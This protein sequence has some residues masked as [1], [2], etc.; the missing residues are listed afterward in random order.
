MKLKNIKNVFIRC[1]ELGKS[2][3]HLNISISRPLTG[4][5]QLAHDDY[6]KIYVDKTNNLIFEKEV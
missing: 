5:L 1:V 2:E 4:R 6:R 3:N